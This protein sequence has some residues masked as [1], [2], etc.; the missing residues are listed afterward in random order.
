MDKTIQEAIDAERTSQDFQWGAPD[1]DDYTWLVILMEEVG[2]AAHAVLHG[3]RK[4]SLFELKIELRQVAAVAIAWLEQLKRL[5][6]Q[7][8]TT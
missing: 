7:E 8:P 6:G 4:A 3:G 1:H 2:E 5:E